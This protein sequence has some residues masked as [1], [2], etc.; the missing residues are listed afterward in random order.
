MS[1]ELICV[2]A[3]VG[4]FGV[5][6]E[7]RLKSYTANPT[8]IA[9]YAPFQ[10]LDGTK[11]FDIVLTGQV[12]KGLTARMSGIVTKEEADDLKGTELYVPKSRL[13]QLPDD[14]YYYSD[15]VGLACSI[16]AALCWELYAASKTMAPLTFS[17]LRCPTH[18]PPFCYHLPNNVFQRST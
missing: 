18:Q 5:K 16:Q 3:I 6:G 4:A 12:K 7:V 1:Q 8:D 13:P 10:T 11:Q 2:G 14:E 15:L 9:N 17:K